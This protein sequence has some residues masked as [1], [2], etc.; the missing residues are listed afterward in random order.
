MAKSGGRFDVKVFLLE[1]PRRI[2]PERCNDIANTPLSSSLITG[3]IAGMLHHLGHDIRIIEGFLDKLTY[4]EIHQAIE[5]AS[6]DVLGVHLIYN[7]E[8]NH[9][10]FTFLRRLKTENRV[11]KIAGYGYYPTFAYEEIFNACPE[12]DA[13][14]IGEPEITFA[15][16]LQG[17]KPAPGM[18]WIDETGRVQAKRREINRNLDALPDPIRTEAMMRMGEVNIEGSRGC[19]GGCTFCYINRYYGEKSCWRSKSPERIVEEIDRIIARH[20]IRKFYFTDPNFFGPGKKGQARAQKIAALLQ[21]RKIRF[22][23][24][25]RVNDIHP[26][27]IADLIDA[28]LEDMLIGLESG[29]DESLKRL[30]KMTTAAQNER[31]L[32]ILR[33]NGIEPSIGFIMFEPD[34]S[35]A[36]IRINFEFLKRNDLLTDLFTTANVLY[37]PQIILQ[38]TKAY[39]DLQRNGKLILKNTAYEGATRYSVPEVACIANI[40]GRITNHFFVSVNRVWN[41][42]IQEPSQAASLYAEINRM[43]VDAFESILHR[44]EA[45]ESIDECTTKTIIDEAKVRIESVFGR[46]PEADQNKDEMPVNSAGVCTSLQ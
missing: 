39:N 29:N 1:H 44:L 9:R 23:I 4:D 32:K 24:E 25:G 35:L 7:W 14:L 27:T 30:N 12:F 15:Q 22:G 46:F 16:W 26:E 37:H 42:D 41:G 3:S 8:N 13:I 28:G 43:M 45:G 5:M 19:Y 36:D 2:A 40:I 20:G 11:G 34:A 31:A 21:K 10:L 18:A 38:G 6:P 33:D 17:L